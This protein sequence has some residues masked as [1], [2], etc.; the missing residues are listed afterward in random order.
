MTYK[1]EFEIRDGRLVHVVPATGPVCDLCTGEPAVYCYP[2]RTFILEAWHWRS[3][4]SWAACAGCAALVEAG[5]LEGLAQRCIHP[6][7]GEHTE[8]T[9]ARAAAIMAAHAAF[10]ANRCG[11]RH[12]HHPGEHAG[13]H[14]Y[15]G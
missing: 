8:V 9:A 7:P 1:P 13:P 4:G 15:P 6:R 14:S 5:D 2:A 3:I 10:L 11:P 12:G